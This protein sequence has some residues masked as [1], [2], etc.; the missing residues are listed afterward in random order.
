MTDGL[1]IESVPFRDHYLAVYRRPGR[2]DE[3]LDGDDG[4]PRRFPSATAAIAA[5]KLALTFVRST[6]E[7]KVEDLLGTATWHEDRAATA[8]SQQLDALGGIVVRGRLIP[9]ERRRR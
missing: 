4:K 3:I 9:V 5:A 2:P 8:V 1:R 6:R 7:P